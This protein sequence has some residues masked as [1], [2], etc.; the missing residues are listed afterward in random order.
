MVAVEGISDVHPADQ[1]AVEG[2]RGGGD[3]TVFVDGPGHQRAADGITHGPHGQE[4][5]AAGGDGPAGSLCP[6][7]GGGALDGSRE[8]RGGQ[9]APPAEGVV[10]AVV[11]RP[12]DETDAVVVAG[13]VGG[14]VGD[15]ARRADGELAAAHQAV[16]GGR[17]DIDAVV[18]QRDDDVRRCP[19]IYRGHG[20]A[21]RLRSDG[22]LAGLV[23]VP[24]PDGGGVELRRH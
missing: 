6:G 17:V 14:G 16:G 12:D 13:D 21:G 19:P 20:D 4:A 15:V 18:F 2:Q 1:A 24:G 23:G 8:L 9:H 10:A 5:A 3:G 22:C 7:G 11:R